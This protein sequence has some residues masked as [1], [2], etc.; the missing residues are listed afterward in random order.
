[1]IEMLALS[2]LNELRKATHIYQTL[3]KFGNIIEI[4]ALSRL[5]EFIQLQTNLCNVIET[6]TFNLH[7]LMA[8]R[9]LHYFEINTSDRP[10]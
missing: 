2:R 5:N 1:M 3:N 9:S 6:I 8:Y 4:L 10:L 7:S